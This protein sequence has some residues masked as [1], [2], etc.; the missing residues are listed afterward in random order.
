MPGA[1]QATELYGGSQWPR[2]LVTVPLVCGRPTE[3][4]DDPAGK[5]VR[6]L[7]TYLQELTDLFP[8]QVFHIGQFLVF[9]LGLFVT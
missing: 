5:T 8:D 7:T 2:P 6:T 1:W 9:L 3:L 4:Y